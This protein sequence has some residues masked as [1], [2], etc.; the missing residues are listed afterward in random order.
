M[1]HITIMYEF[2]MCMKTMMSIKSGIET[3][4]S[5]SDWLCFR[6]RVSGWVWRLK[7]TSIKRNG[8]LFLYCLSTTAKRWLHFYITATVMW[9]FQTVLF[10]S[11]CK[12]KCKCKCG[13]F[14]HQSVQGGKKGIKNPNL[15]IF[16]FTFSVWFVNFRIMI[17]NHDDVPKNKRNCE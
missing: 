4:T 2:T 15:D 10:E 13:N 3:G 14:K 12:C 6:W 8:E 1:Y 11:C 9:E 5:G 17:M 7:F 16:C